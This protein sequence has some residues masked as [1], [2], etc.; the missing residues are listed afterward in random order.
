MVVCHLFRFILS[1][2]FKLL[3]GPTSPL[4]CFKISMFILSCDCP[5]APTMSAMLL[6]PSLILPFS[7]LTFFAFLLVAAS[8]WRKEPPWRTWCCAT[9]VWPCWR[10]SWSSASSCPLESQQN[11]CVVLHTAL[12]QYNIV[13]EE[14][15]LRTFRVL[16][17][18][19]FLL[20]QC[21]CKWQV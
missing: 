8:C 4:R 11:V 3:T 21:I 15:A 20:L 7:L 19:G 17:R 9:V 2:Y 6:R 13:P 14:R 18:V 10:P 12:A 5:A 1:K 16:N